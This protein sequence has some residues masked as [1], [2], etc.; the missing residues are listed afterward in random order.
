MH[1]VGA[2]QF[3]W[4][5]QDFIVIVD[6]HS[7]YLEVLTLSSTSSG[8]TIAAMKS[9]FAPHGIPPS[10][11]T[12]NGP[13]FASGD[14]AKFAK[15]YGFQHQTSSPRFLQSN[16]EAERA[17]RT[18]KELLTKVED[19]YLALLRY[20][21]TPGVSRDSPA[22]VLFG[23]RLR[24]RL[25]RAQDE[26]PPRPPSPARVA[27]RNELYKWKQAQAFNQR[28]AARELPPLRP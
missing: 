27:R 22:Q 14:F 3:H 5:K 23:R 17:V 9:A 26:S 12:D 10:V 25:P 19:P 16:G 21:N 8:A 28:H 2:D 4:K 6:Y 11:R 7:R 15:G 20:G 24:T 13:Q 1:H 18:I